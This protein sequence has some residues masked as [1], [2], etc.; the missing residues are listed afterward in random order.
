MVEQITGTSSDPVPAPEDRYCCPSSDRQI[1]NPW[2]SQIVSSN[3]TFSNDTLRKD[4]IV[5][6]I[7]I[8]GT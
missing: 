7:R 5:I 4:T 1:T 8:W 3:T 6:R 2:N